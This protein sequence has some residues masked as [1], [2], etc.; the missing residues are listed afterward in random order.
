MDEQSD[1]T[2]EEEVIDKGNGQLEIDELV[3]CRMRSTK[4]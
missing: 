1:E 3:L 4:R 2:K